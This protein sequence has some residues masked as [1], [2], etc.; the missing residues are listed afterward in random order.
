M[1]LALSTWQEVERYLE[2]ST[3][4]IIP[5]GSTEQHGPNGLIGTDAIC[6]LRISQHIETLQDVL[7]APS[8]N[9]GMSAHHMAFA[10]SVTLKPSTLVQVIIDVV[11]SLRRHGFTHYYFLNG[12]GGNIP[13]VTAAFSEL[14]ADVS[15]GD[16]SLRCR[17]A[18]WWRDAAVKQLAAELYGEAEGFHATVSEVALSYYAYPEAVKDVPLSPEVAPTGEFFD[19]FDFRQKFPDGRIGSSPQLATVKDGERFCR[20]AADALLAD[21]LEF[22]SA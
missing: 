5:I 7:I 20:L 1:Q 14:Y 4:I 12:H 15:E 17:M 2:R 19:A 3:G 22:L 10:G 11:G 9:Y 6:P 21:Y 8:I 13:A 16:L 18:N